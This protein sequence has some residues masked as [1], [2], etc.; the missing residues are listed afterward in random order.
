LPN[1]ENLHTGIAEV[2]LTS[3]ILRIPYHEPVGTKSLHLVGCCG[4]G[5]YSL[6]TSRLEVS[7]H[8]LVEE[9]EEEGSVTTGEILEAD[10]MCG[11]GVEE[12]DLSVVI[13]IVPVVIG[14]V[15]ILDFVYLSL[16]HENTVTTCDR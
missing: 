4:D 12:R 15:P 14:I 6:I 5:L 2:D 13:R 8:C 10:P 1:L 3:A 11:V 16:C 9:V 7:P